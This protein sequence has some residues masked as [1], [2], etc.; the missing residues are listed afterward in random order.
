MPRDY[1]EVFGVSRGASAEEIKAAFRKLAHQ[2]H[3]DKAGGN[4]EKFKEINEAY[5]VLSNPE[6]RQQYDRYG[7]TFEHA[8]AQGGFSGFGSFRDFADFTEAFRN[9]NGSS[10]GSDFGNLG[11]LFGGLGE[12]FGARAAGRSRADRGQDLAVEIA[13]G[14]RE[15]VFGTTREL[16]LDR[17]RACQTCAGRGAEPGSKLTRC[18]ACGGQG[19]VVRSFGLGFG[20]STVCNECGGRGEKPE[21]ICRSC[22]GRGLRARRETI[23]IKIPAGIDD[24]QAIRIA[25]EG[26]AARGA[27]AG[28]LYVR[29]RVVPDQR[30]R[31]T[32][33][34]LETTLSVSF[35][36]AALGGTVT[37]E[38]LDGPTALKI[39]EGTLSGQVIRLRGK[40]VP[41]VQGRGRGDLLARVQVAT[42]AKLTRRQRQLLE[43][44]RQEL[45]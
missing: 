29:V 22:R 45:G 27:A 28:D 42:P 6:K 36:T 39:P 1:Y 43:E 41:N 8:R 37:L 13:L 19:Q 20:L 5:Q 31:R 10:G 17:D 26:Q 9:G 3:P 7:A 2:H 23:T 18:R 24:G 40:G 15:A 33:D 34:N 12:I 16:A 21:K 14:F 25:G 38:T 35:P 30:F 32:G 4:A 44:L 11:D